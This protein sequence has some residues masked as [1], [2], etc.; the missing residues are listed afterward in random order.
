[1]A[2]ALEK[3]FYHV[4]ILAVTS[5]LSSTGFHVVSSLNRYF[6][7]TAVNVTEERV[8]FNF[9]AFNHSA[10]Q[11]GDGGSRWVPEKKNS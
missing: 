7:L 11:E 6:D 8:E 4:A 10:P 5:V 2:I 9:Q 1:M 3:K